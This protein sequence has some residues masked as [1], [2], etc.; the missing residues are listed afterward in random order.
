MV[1]MQLNLPI[2][3]RADDLW[4][5]GL[6]NRLP[7][8]DKVL[9][10]LG[11]DQTTYD[12]IVHDAHVLGE[13]RAV[14]AGLL[15]YE[16]RIEPG[17]DS[18]AGRRATELAREIFNRA[19]YQNGQWPDVIWNI[20]Q[21]VFRGY[22]VHDIVWVRDGQYIVPEQIID[23]PNRRFIFDANDNRLKVLTRA[24]PFDGEDIPDKQILLTQHM[25]SHDNPY[26]VAVFSACF[27]P[28]IFKHSGFRY[29]VKF[30]EKFG[31]P[32]VLGKYPVS[33]D[34]AQVEKLVNALSELIN[35]AVAAVQEDHEI[36]PVEAHAT[37]GRNTPQERLIAVCNTEMSKALTSQT[38]AT[39]IQGE[40]SRAASQT[41]LE[42]ERGVHH[43]D[44]QMIAAT[45]NR[46]FRWL[47][48]INFGEQVAAPTFHF[49][50][51]GQ[52][53]TAWAELFDKARHYLPIRRNDAYE[54]L[55]LTPPADG[56]EVLSAG[57]AGGEPQEFAA[58]DTASFRQATDALLAVADQSDLDSISHQL[59][60][61]I[62]NTARNQPDHLLVR[63]A[64]AYP[65]IDTDSLEDRL[66]RLIFV[67][68]VAGESEATDG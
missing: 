7:N 40:G 5:A 23:R 31:V 54:R 35:N 49:Y 30:C 58:G 9:R 57:G 22:A 61:P 56:D 13:L 51:E 28:F 19:P 45:I 60:Q 46:L 63:L 47:T 38:L 27:W 48:D 2:G 62:L 36:V 32:W 15:A 64:Q 65:D 17:D 8:P 55:G 18:R 12:Q 16:F 34:S 20:A 21:A 25:P 50:E 42:R 4:Y 10:K 68:A 33:T 11:R 59:V 37:A 26:G 29:F 67:A 52:A 1:Q 53:H 6:W 41:H 44:R 14:R 66:E 3:S 43:S 39:E 24:Q